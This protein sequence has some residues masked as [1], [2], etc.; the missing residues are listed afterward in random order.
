[1]L[2]R[3]YEAYTFLIIAALNAI[4]QFYENSTNVWSCISAGYHLIGCNKFYK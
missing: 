2:N 3:K 1:M 4:L